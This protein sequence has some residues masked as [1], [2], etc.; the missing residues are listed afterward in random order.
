MPSYQKKHK[1]FC[2]PQNINCE[3]ST[4]NLHTGT[5]SVER[6][7]QSMENLI[8]ANLEDGTNLRESVNRALHVLRFTIHSQTKKTVQNPFRTGTHK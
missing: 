6:T 2:K 3:Y 4:A 5:G 7:M 8:L 1:D